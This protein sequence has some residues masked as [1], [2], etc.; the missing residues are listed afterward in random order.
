MERHERDGLTRGP[1]GIC[2][3]P[4]A[5]G[6]GFCPSEGGEDATPTVAKGGM[7]ANTNHSN[8]WR[9]VDL[10]TVWSLQPMQIFN[11]L[12]TVGARQT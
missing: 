3:L 9:G 7:D 6:W 4:A 10:W 1:S 11:T 12:G 2:H 5:I 8:A